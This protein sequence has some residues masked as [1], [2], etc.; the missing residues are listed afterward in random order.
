MDI[1][2]DKVWKFIMK[3]QL[4]RPGDHVVTGLSGGA[5]SVC[6]LL[7]LHELSP[8]LQLTLTAV[9]VH[10][11]IRGEAADRDMEYAESLCRE[12]GI[13]FLPVWSDVPRRA[14]ENHQTV[15][16]AGREARYEAFVRAAGE[17][18]ANVI[19]VAH[20]MD[21]QAETV[22]MNLLRGSGIRGY[23]GI[24]PKRAIDSEGVL[25]R[26]PQFSAAEPKASLCVVR[27]LLCL[28]RC[29][30]E[31]WLGS[32]GRQ[33]CTDETNAETDYLRSR[34]RNCLMPQLESCYNSEAL[35]HIAAA[36]GDFREADEYLR[37]QARGLM[38][39]WKVLEESGPEPSRAVYPVRLL[40]EQPSILQRYAI[41]EGIGSLCGLK[42]ISR[43]HI[44]A[45]LSLLGKS[46]QKQISLPGGLQARLCYGQLFL[47]QRGR[48]GNLH[49]RSV[50]SC[51][52]EKNDQA[53]NRAVFT[54][55][56]YQDKKIPQNCCVNWFDY[57]TIGGSLL[58]RRRRPGDRICVRK[59]GSNQKLSDY[60]IN[61]KIPAGQR[62]QLPLLACGRDILWIPGWRMAE[63]C[64]V[65]KKT[66]LIL[67]VKLEQPVYLE[68]NRMKD[69]G[70]QGD[71]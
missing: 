14:R 64:K 57:D 13:V 59:D 34:V 9:H 60:M 17:R 68:D 41:Q 31:Q 48:S 3:Q 35:E 7:M 26:G 15:E 44:E 52:G 71:E 47:E 38:E 19:A 58:V 36:A 25:S 62:D 23:G 24:S 27:P 53:L 42:D 54:V 40:A 65:T 2:L 22:M 37:S 56:L 8:R 29:E 70:E 21:D 16:E 66:R 43:R 18:G 30:I 20:H 33:W 50:V 67:Q 51:P 61:A 32:R 12:L 49:H 11:G 4:V 55:F 6:L 28:R 10:H 39:S 45:I 63:N 46:G 5:D 69:K 1:L